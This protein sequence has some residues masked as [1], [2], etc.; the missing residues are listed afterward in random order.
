MTGQS[1][2]INITLVLYIGAPLACLS[3]AGADVITQWLPGTVHLVHFH[4]CYKSPSG[5][6]G[7]LPL[8]PF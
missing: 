2:F 8:I 3:A 7:V 6:Q 5:H 4:Y 1:V